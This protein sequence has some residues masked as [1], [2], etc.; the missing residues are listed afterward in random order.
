MQ[1]LLPSTCL[2]SKSQNPRHRGPFSRL[3]TRAI[4]DL[5][6]YK[7]GA[8]VNPRTLSALV[9]HSRWASQTLGDAVSQQN[10]WRKTMRLLEARS[11]IGNVCLL[12]SRPALRMPL[13]SV[14]KN[15]PPRGG[16]LAS[17]EPGQLSLRAYWKFLLKGHGR[18]TPSRRRNRGKG[19]KI[20][21]V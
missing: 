7:P 1:G 4:L 5:S 21:D 2:P 17:Q 9:Q 13:Q 18:G 14:A 8:G 3:K 11:L 15:F 20:T 19:E 6:H 12:A 16:S 10:H